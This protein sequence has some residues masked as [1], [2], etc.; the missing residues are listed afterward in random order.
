MVVLGRRPERLR[1]AGAVAADLALDSGGDWSAQLR[2]RCPG[3]IDVFCEAVG[4]PALLRQGVELLRPGG[5]AAVYGVAPR[6]QTMQVEGLTEGRRLIV[7]EAREH[8]AYAWV[9]D[10]T[11]PHPSHNPV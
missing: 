5:T 11:Y 4:S 7:P 8:L 10:R 1:L 2:R 6:G 3:G 9:L